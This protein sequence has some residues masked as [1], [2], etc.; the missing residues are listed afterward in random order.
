MYRME[1]SSEK[2]VVLML[3]DSRAV[4]HTQSKGATVADP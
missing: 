3:P 1:I 4:R 2:G